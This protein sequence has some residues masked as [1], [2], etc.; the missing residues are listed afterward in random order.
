MQEYIA[1][2]KNYANFSDRTSVRGYWMAWLINFIVSAIIAAVATMLKLDILST[3]YSLAVLVPG[4]AIAVRR[5]N[6]C[7][8]SW[9]SL[10]WYLC[11]IVGWIIVIVRLCK[12]SIP[13]VEGEAVVESVPVEL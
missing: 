12:K 3:V 4:L 11:P 5:L 13:V 8:H 9:K 1:M 7:G 6:D 10:L 2:W